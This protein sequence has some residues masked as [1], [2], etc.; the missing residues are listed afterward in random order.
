MKVPNWLFD[1]FPWLFPKKK[2][3]VKA[4]LEKILQ[5]RWIVVT[6]RL[7]VEDMLLPKLELIQLHVA[8]YHDGK[9]TL[10]YSK[11][12]KGNEEITRTI[13]HEITHHIQDSKNPHA[14]KTYRIDVFSDLIWVLTGKLRFGLAQRAFQ[15]GFATY[16][17]HLTSRKLAERVE[18]GIIMIQNGKRLKTLFKDT[19]VLPYVLGYLGYSAIA[20]TKSEKQAIQLGLSANSSEWISESEA[21]L[22]KVPICDL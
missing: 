21:A 12:F 22:A 17:A 9:V 16:V 7:H 4:E 11:I 5:E 6:K 14:R 15:E 2:K 3:M 10:S 13:D 18:N 8:F 20:K 1:L 19:E